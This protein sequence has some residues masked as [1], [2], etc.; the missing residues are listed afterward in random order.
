[1]ISVYDL[2][3][4]LTYDITDKLQEFYCTLTPEFSGMTYVDGEEADYGIIRWT[5]KNNILIAEQHVLA[6]DDSYSKFTVDG[7][8][9]LIAMLTEVIYNMEIDTLEN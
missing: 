1:M 9:I 4:N 6:G 8:R 5:N 7:K 3:P 2:F